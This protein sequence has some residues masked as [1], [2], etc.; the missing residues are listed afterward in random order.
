MRVR[1]SKKRNTKGQ[2]SRSAWNIFKPLIALIAFTF[3]MW[4]IQQYFKEQELLSPCPEDGCT[5]NF[6]VRAMEVEPVEEVKTTRQEIVEYIFKVFGDDAVEAIVIIRK[7][8][9]SQFNPKA[10]NWN[11]NGTWDTGIFQINQIHGYSLEQMQ[12]CKQNIDAAK[13]IFDRAGDWSPWGCSHVV[14]VT[15]LYLK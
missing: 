1:K 5:F 10:T 9:N 15:P 14:G 13:K 12:D 11:R 7:C 8:E 3:L 6:Q 4:C 2:Y